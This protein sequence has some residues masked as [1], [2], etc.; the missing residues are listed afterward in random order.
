MMFVFER[1]DGFGGLFSADDEQPKFIIVVKLVPEFLNVG[2][3]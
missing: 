2:Q 3:L 1:L